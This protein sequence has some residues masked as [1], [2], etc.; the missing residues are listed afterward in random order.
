MI[1]QLREALGYRWMEVAE[2][3]CFALVL[4]V[5][6]VLII[7]TSRL[8]VA[9][10]SSWFFVVAM[11]TFSFYYETSLYDRGLIVSAPSIVMIDAVIIDWMLVL[12]YCIVL[13]LLKRALLKFSRL[14][15][16][17]SS[18][19]TVAVVIFV[20]NL[21]PHYG[22]AHFRYTGSEIEREV[23]NIG[24]PIALAIYDP[25]TVQRSHIG[26]FSPTIFQGPIS[27]MPKQVSP[28]S[29]S[30]VNDSRYGSAALIL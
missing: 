22:T 12:L 9:L 2:H 3:L 21:F 5:P 4:V 30:S 25:E 29:W 8:W 18:L 26:P 19:L 16:G 14:N 17:N 13:L 11:K 28:P 27:I 6:I 15:S 10:L 7:D 23:W 1:E 20:L 24:P